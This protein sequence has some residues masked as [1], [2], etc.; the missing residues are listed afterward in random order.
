MGSYVRRMVRLMTISLLSCIFAPCRPP[1]NSP[2]NKCIVLCCRLLWIHWLGRTVRC[3]CSAGHHSPRIYNWGLCLT[4]PHPI[5]KTGPK[6]TTPLSGRSPDN[7]SL[8][9]PLAEDN[10]TS[11][12][13]VGGRVPGPVTG[14][15][16]DSAVY[17]GRVRTPVE[18]T[19]RRRVGPF[20]VV[21]AG[22]H[23]VPDQRVV[24]V[25]AVH[26]PCAVTGTAVLQDD[27]TV[28]QVW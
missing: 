7:D 28:V 17:F 3:R 4:I 20:A 18:Q 27:G 13:S 5:H 12:A 10:I 1:T 21:A 9:H 22:P 6:A 8:A 25:A 16:D 2:Q 11:L 15:G 24:L 23:L 19:L 26:R 14:G